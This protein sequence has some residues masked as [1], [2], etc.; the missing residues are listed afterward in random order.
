[1]IYSRD[2]G[3]GDGNRRR[4]RVRILVIN[5]GSSSLKYRIFHMA[6]ERELD[7]GA[8]TGL[9]SSAD[10][11]GPRR[12]A[13]RRIFEAAGTVAGVGHRVV[14]GGAAHR[15][16][17]RVDD[18][19]LESLQGLNALAPLHNPACLEGIALALEAAPGVPQVAVFDTA[20]FA[21][22]PE[23]AWRYALPRELADRYGVRRY[24]F[25]GI[26]HG[27]VAAAA[28]RQLDRPLERLR[29]VTLHLGHGASAAAVAGGRC[30]ETSMGMTPLEGL[31]MGTRSGDLDPAVVA[32]LQH[33]TGMGPDG[34]EALLNRESGL[35][36]LCGEA[37]MRTVRARAAAGDGA[38]R[39]AIDVFVHRIRK[40]VG[41]Y[42]AVL[43][44]LDALVFTGGIGEHDAALRAEVCAGLAV[45]G[46]ALDPQRNDA[47]RTVISRDDA[48]AAVLVV[49]TNEELAIARATRDL[50]VD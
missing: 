13:L 5:S 36:G 25:H 21:D 46:V 15:S 40:Y 6:G 19:V 45:L 42:A 4:H 7:R 29:L 27:Y 47:G 44:G 28:A 34:V 38:A 16:P 9:D 24:G 35:R 8:F 18:S 17:V 12:E 14:H 2:H 23:H 30:V 49:P 37:D 33:H 50:L 41:G 3:H 31:V 32:M 11:T 20:Y 10:D 43:G 22:L 48:P 39:L 1:M 26:S